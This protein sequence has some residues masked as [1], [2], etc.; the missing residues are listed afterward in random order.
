M[1]LAYLRGTQWDMLSCTRTQVV[2]DLFRLIPF[3]FFIIV[4]AMELLLPLAL[5]LFP[6]MIPSQFQVRCYTSFSH[7]IS[8]WCKLQK[9]M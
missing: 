3:S 8:I 9:H 6:N 2:V 7:Q 4:P 5:K 1:P